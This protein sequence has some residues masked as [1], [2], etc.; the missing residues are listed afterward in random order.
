MENTQSISINRGKNSY[1]TTNRHTKDDITNTNNQDVTTSKKKKRQS[2]FDDSNN[3]DKVSKKKKVTWG[4]H[5][6]NIVD[7]QSFKKYNLENCHD[8]PNTI[9]PNTRCACVIF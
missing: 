5:A 8:D 7:V 2:K 9:K 6:V 3:R 1:D 4:K